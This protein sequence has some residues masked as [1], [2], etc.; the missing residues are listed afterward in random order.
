MSTFSAA[1][2]A[3]LDSQPLGR[4]ATADGQPHVMPVGGF[5]DP[6]TETL[7]IGSVADM[8]ASKKFRPH[9]AVVVDELAGAAARDVA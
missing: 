5:H 9:S 4:V 1:E 2:L 8:A 6:S 3:Y 7:V